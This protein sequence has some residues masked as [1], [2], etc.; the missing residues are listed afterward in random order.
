M[1][2]ELE[3][4]K[5]ENEAHIANLM[6]ISQDK[7]NEVQVKNVSLQDELQY[8]KNE[9][10]TL[11]QRIALL[12]KQCE[13]ANASADSYSFSR[14]SQQEFKELAIKTNHEHY[15]LITELFICLKN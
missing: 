15:D 14:F 4:N 7:Y 5:R 3:E 2:E 13:D 10:A 6:K 1:K 8:E 11:M 9:N 12:E